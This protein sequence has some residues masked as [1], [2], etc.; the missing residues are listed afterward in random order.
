MQ[1]RNSSKQHWEPSLSCPSCSPSTPQRR[2]RSAVSGENDTSNF[3]ATTLQPCYRTDHV[4]SEHSCNQW[5]ICR[6]E[7]AR[8]KYNSSSCSMGVTMA[9]FPLGAHRSASPLAQPWSSSRDASGTL[10]LRVRGATVTAMRWLLRRTNA[11]ACHAH[12]QSMRARVGL[13]CTYTHM[14]DVEFCI[15][16]LSVLHKSYRTQ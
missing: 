9:I 5:H 16:E 4:T 14:S 15:H 11:L 10:L 12:R 1:C 3:V 8:E 6:K 7:N 13:V 2:P